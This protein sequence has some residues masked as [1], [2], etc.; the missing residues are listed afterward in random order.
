MLTPPRGSRLPGVRDL[1]LQLN[2][3]SPKRRLEALGVLW[4]LE[5]RLP[6]P[7]MNID[8]CDSDVPGSTVAWWRTATVADADQLQRRLALVLDEI[9]WGRHGAA[10]TQFD[11]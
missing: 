10:I 11:A 2:W 8:H 4:E 7:A 5:R 3:D 1:F 6:E 9:G